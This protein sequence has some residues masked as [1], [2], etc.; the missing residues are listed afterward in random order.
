MTNG[1]TDW[2]DKIFWMALIGMGEWVVRGLGAISSVHRG[3][4]ASTPYQRPC[5][6][7]HWKEK[8]PDSHGQALN[9]AHQSERN[10][11]II[12]RTVH[13]IPLH[14]SPSKIHFDTTVPANYLSAEV[15]PLRKF[16]ANVNISLAGQGVNN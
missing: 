2:V 13:L 11:Q 1:R 5:D 9:S 6:L 4:L 3:S 10:L 14:I 16:W 12:R 15:C 7:L 8:S